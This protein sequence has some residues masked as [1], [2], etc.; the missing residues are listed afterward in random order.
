MNQI[1]FLII[2][3][4]YLK[5]NSFKNLWVNLVQYFNCISSINVKSWYYFIDIHSRKII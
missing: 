5:T 1:G 4:S 3:C 2:V